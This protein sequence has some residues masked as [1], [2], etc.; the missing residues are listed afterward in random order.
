MQYINITKNK[1][2]NSIHS[3]F[4]TQTKFVMKENFE[5]VDKTSIMKQFIQKNN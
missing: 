1:K 3:T 5:T 4:Y 2:N